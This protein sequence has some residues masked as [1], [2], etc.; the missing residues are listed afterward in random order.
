[1]AR[2][3]AR[4]SP[5]FTWHE[6]M[7]NIVF[8]EIPVPGRASPPRRSVHVSHSCFGGLQRRSPSGLQLP[9]EKHVLLFAQPIGVTSDPRITFPYLLK[10]CASTFGLCALQAA[11]VP[12]GHPSLEGPVNLVARGS[13]R[14]HQ[15]RRP[16]QTLIEPAAP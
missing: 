16:A 2:P 1:M 5:A 3:I 14:H 10:I 13:I 15:R 7:S 12:R 8:L 4:A 6:V 11:S 9:G